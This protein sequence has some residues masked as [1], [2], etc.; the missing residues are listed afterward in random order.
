MSDNN[1]TVSRKEILI[2]LA[3]AFGVPYVMGLPMYLGHSSGADVSVFPLAQMLYPAA[4]VMLAFLITRRH[5]PVLPRGFF[6]FFF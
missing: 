3:V 5:D 4:G 6:C 1:K 2:F